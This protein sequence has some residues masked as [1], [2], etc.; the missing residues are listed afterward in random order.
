LSTAA[1]FNVHLNPLGLGFRGLERFQHGGQQ[2][3]LGRGFDHAWQNT[4]HDFFR[5]LLPE[6]AW[7]AM[8]TAKT[9]IVVPHHVL[10]YFP[11]AALVTR[12]DISQRRPTEM[13][14]PRFLV[15]E[16]FVLCRAPSLTIWDLLRRE[17]KEPIRDVNVVGIAEFPSAVPLPGVEEDLNNLREVFPGRIRTI[18]TGR[19]VRKDNVQAILDR[20]GLMF[21]ATHGENT[22]SRP[23]PATCC[24]IPIRIRTACCLAAISSPAGLGRAW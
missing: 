13:P 9:V 4:L 20:D 1:H 19:N 18:L 5:E 21:I 17:H 11:F 8:G 22:P 14:V 10:H 12:R 23:W 15:E 16:P 6:P 2:L 24:A 3:L 7:K